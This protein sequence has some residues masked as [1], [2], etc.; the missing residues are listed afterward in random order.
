VQID[1]LFRIDTPFA[2]EDFLEPDDDL[3]RQQMLDLIGGPV[4]VVSIENRPVIEIVL[5]QSM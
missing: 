3:R 2:R 5:P 1:D 4:H